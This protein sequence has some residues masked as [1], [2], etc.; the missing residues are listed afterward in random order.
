MPPI[1]FFVAI[2]VL[3]LLG[4]V[5]FAVAWVAFTPIDTPVREDQLEL[6][7]RRAEK[8]IHSARELVGAGR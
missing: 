2:G 5:G 4:L 8:E 7:L 3:L 6:S 1:S